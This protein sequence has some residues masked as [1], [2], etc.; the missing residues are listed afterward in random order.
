MLTIAQPSSLL[1]FAAL[2]AAAPASTS[3]ASDDVRPNVE[4]W[5]VG[6]RRYESTADLLKTFTP[7]SNGEP[8]VYHWRQ[9][10]SFGWPEKKTAMREGALTG[11][12]VGGMLGGALA[13]G[14]NVLG[15]AATVLTAGMMGVFGGVGLLAP[16]AIGAGLGAVMG[17]IEGPANAKERFDTGTLVGGQLQSEL[18]P[19]GSQHL[20][21]YVN[22]QVNQKVDLNS[23]A[24]AQP[25]PIPENGPEPWWI[26]GSAQQ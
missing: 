5:E 11:A 22:G 12:L 6:D 10:T 2:P 26:S 7:S 9:E 8:A 24:T 25:G 23:Y 18:Q 4:W 14:I 21:F 20:E 3:T 16:I 15:F 17:A 1:H 19:D 13:V